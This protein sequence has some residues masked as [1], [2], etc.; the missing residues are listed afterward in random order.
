MKNWRLSTPA[1][2]PLSPARLS[3]R[4]Q[5]TDSPFAQGPWWDDLTKNRGSE[6]ALALETWQWE[7]TEHALAEWLKGWFQ[8]TEIAGGFEPYPSE[9][10]LKWWTSSAGMM[11]FST[12]GEKKIMFQTTNQNWDWTTIW[13]MDGYGGHEWRTGAA[14]LL[15]FITQLRSIRGESLYPTHTYLKAAFHHLYLSCPSKKIQNHWKCL[16]GVYENAQE[17][18]F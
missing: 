14:D 1:V 7:V 3:P 17:W 2:Q 5:A 4:A 15:I 12:Y 13:D 11:T 8:A 9:K 18:T 16:M 10:I 6:Q